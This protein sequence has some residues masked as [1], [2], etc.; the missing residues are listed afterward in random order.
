MP[1]TDTRD[2]ACPSCGALAPEGARFCPSCGQVLEGPVE[3]E[4]RVVTVVFADLAGFTTLA[5]G[6]DPEQ[7][8]ELLDR[9]ASPAP[10]PAPTREEA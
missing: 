2:L 5:E 10:S 4:R 7:V 8:K 3:Q 1:D 6:R 9:A